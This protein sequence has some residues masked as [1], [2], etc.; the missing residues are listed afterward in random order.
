[1]SSTDGWNGVMQ[2]EDPAGLPV[3]ETRE[4]PRHWRT[5]TEERLVAL[6]RAELRMLGEAQS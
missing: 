4:L 3:A 6:I 1:M 2:A 5:M